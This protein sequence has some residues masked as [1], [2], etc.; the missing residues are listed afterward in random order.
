MR[1]RST[2]ARVQELVRWVKKHKDA[3]MQDFLRDT[4][5]KPSQYYH[6]R[7]IAGIKKRNPNLSEAMKKVA[8]RK[9]MANA[10]EAILKTPNG[11]VI[12][13]MPEPETKDL[14]QAMKE[15]AMEEFAK[16]TATEVAVEGNTPD[17]IWYEIDLLQR[18]LGDISARLAHVMKVSQTR[19]ADQKKMMRQLISENTELRVNNNSL[20][21]QVAELTEMINGSPV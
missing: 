19:D 21:Q 11:D 1:T 5:G 7:S 13:K 16:P 9:K 10:K 20:T 4:G 14:K 8:M 17:F 18:K 3:S 6:A 15:M 2:A 12:L